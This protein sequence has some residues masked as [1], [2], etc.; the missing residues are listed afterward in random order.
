MLRLSVGVAGVLLTVGLAHAEPAADVYNNCQHASDTKLKIESCT[1][2]IDRGSQETQAWRAAAFA[3]RGDVYFG[4]ANYTAALADY[5]QA[6]KLNPN[7]VNYFDRGVAHA[8]L[9]ERLLALADLDQAI[10]MNPRVGQ[11]FRSRGRTWMEHGEP[12]LAIADLSQAIRLDPQDD[13][14][15]FW[16]A[17]AHRRKLEYHLAQADLDAS[18]GI[19]PSD[20]IVKDELTDVADTL[21]NNYGE[22]LAD[23][24][25]APQSTLF[26]QV[27]GGTPGSIPG[28]EVISTPLLAD[29]FSKKMKFL[30]IDVLKTK[31][32][33]MAG[34]E[35]LDYAGD[36]GSFDDATQKRLAADLEKLTGKD[37]AYIL[38]FFCAGSNCRESYNASLRALALGYTNVFWH[39]GGMAALTD[40]AQRRAAVNA[41]PK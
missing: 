28:G 34:T 19:N 41:A 3:L 16:R 14:A 39:R 15:Y 24:V 33:P 5:D 6:L 12:D 4:D 20:Q 37:K 29:W 32:D 40:I 8:R 23:Y 1:T 13:S 7:E 2:I 26:A 9:G 36:G 10:R 17:K 25:V 35:Y 30:Y 22:E 11:Y 27:G 21:K 18:L 38:A 31:H